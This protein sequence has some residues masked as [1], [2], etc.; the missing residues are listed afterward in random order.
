[1]NLY[2]PVNP[3]PTPV[4]VAN[5]AHL[6][7]TSFQ[8]LLRFY[9]LLTILTFCIATTSAQ[10]EIPARCP[11][12]LF[13]STC[14]NYVPQVVKD[15]GI[16]TLWC[17]ET[18]M[19]YNIGED[20]L[21]CTSEAGGWSCSGSEMPPLL[22]VSAGNWEVCSIDEN[23]IVR[24]K[25]TLD[26]DPVFNGVPLSETGT[27]TPATGTP[28]LCEE[29]N[30][31]GALNAQDS[32]FE[33][34]LCPGDDVRLELE[35]L[36]LV[37]LDGVCF[38]MEVRNLNGN[39]EAKRIVSSFPATGI[40]VSFLFEDLELDVVY[41]LVYRTKC[42]DD[43]SPNCFTTNTIRY[44][45]FKLVGNFAYSAHS[46]SGYDNPVYNFQ[47]STTPPGSILG[48]PTLI[49]PIPGLFFWLNYINFLGYD[50][51][52]PSGVSI[53]YGWYD[54]N[55]TANDPND[56]QMIGG[57]TVNGNDPFSPNPAVFFLLDPSECKCFRLDLTYTDGCSDELM[58]D[59]Y[60]Y[61]TNANCLKGPNDDPPVEFLTGNLG[62]GRGSFGVGVK[63]NPIKD[64]QLVLEWSGEM[65]DQAGPIDLTI[66][67]A[68]GAMVMAQKV[69][70]DGQQLLVPFDAVPGIYFYTVLVDGQAFSGK[71]V[72][73]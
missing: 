62:T 55:C 30:Y 9:L 70:P 52:H 4:I 41:R 38:E 60:Y 5:N 25:M 50:V 11:C 1:M 17:G 44:A 64:G 47:P 22:C 16:A 20:G 63:V 2:L 14:V 10:V 28:T 27:M 36:I 67:N 21:L 69:R 33:L 34:D 56:D 49:E 61:R 46:S 48:S 65:P 51:R 6:L 57:G 32:P 18:S 59:S 31:T 45:Y 15:E 13:V 58:T 71:F 29:V 43:S 42:C 26:I 68:A 7:S 37:D 12:L 8:S 53:Q 39:L 23:C 54:T 19:D 73:N 40:D 35:D 24:L 72:K 66:Q 3:G